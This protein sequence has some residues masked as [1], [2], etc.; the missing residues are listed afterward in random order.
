MIY[1]YFFGVWTPYFAVDMYHRLGGICYL[2]IKGT[3]E[4]QS[5]NLV[6]FAKTKGPH[7]PE[8][9]N[10]CNDFC[11]S[12]TCRGSNLL[13]TSGGDERPFDVT[14]TRITRL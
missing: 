4:A 10:V 7:I 11:E 14:E 9:I 12:P 6:V 8:E 2:S 13:Q 5:G 1:G 3:K